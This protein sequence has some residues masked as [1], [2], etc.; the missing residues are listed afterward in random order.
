[1]KNLGFTLMAFWVCMATCDAGLAGWLTQEQRSW[2]FIECVGGINVTLKNKRLD[3]DC[4]VSGTR[5][6]TKKPTLV[7]SGI[8]VR[9]LR[10]TRAGST[11]RLSVVT[12][13]FEKGMSSSCGGLDLAKVPSG[14]YSVEYLDPDGTTHSLG[15]ITVP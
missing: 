7:N 10:W 3:V 9:K 6:I 1:M 4:D 15:M 5:R 11:I 13:V 14:S 8:G 2:T 12:N